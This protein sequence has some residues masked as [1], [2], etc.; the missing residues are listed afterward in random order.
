MKKH[1][2]LNDARLASWWFA[3]EDLDW[4]DRC[5]SRKWAARAKD[6]QTAGINTAVVFGF[7]FRWDFLP[8]LGRVFGAL[9]EVAEICHDHG[10]R[11]VEH[12]SATL[13]HRV[14]NDEDRW[15]IR[16]D[17][18]HHLP[19]YPD[20][21]D[22]SHYRGAPM[23]EWRQIS[24]RDG[25]PAF[26]NRYTS[27]CFCPNN[28]S[29]Q[30]AYLDLVARH[31]EALPLDAIMS[32]DLHYLPDAYSCGCEHC[33]ARFREEEGLELPPATDSSFWENYENPDFLKWIGARYRWNADHYRSLRESL[34]E[35]MPLWGCASNCVSAELA[36]IGFSPQ[37]WA[38]YCDAIFHEIYHVNQP[39]THDADIASDLAGFASLARHYDKPLLALFYAR[40]AADV[41]TWLETTA[42]HR[43]RPWLSK[44]PRTLGAPIEETLLQNGFP[45]D[46]EK[47]R[48]PEGD[49]HAIVFSESARDRLGPRA[50]EA[51]V[52]PFRRLFA[53]LSA[54]GKTV[55]VV[56]D[57]LWPEERP[58]QWKT[59]RAPGREFL[60]DTVEQR[61][62][63]FES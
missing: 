23:A 4:P 41:P 8:Y 47:A 20:T 34:P 28:P 17:N 24:A 15:E 13:V 33:R 42:F 43:A 39:G 16:N 19:F 38:P 56:F 7:H 53:E 14:R 6:F 55:H 37:H 31:I 60:S 49:L 30:Q 21:W 11:L 51:Y 22:Y 59:L 10:I 3:F 29:F 27:E 1:D 58:A 36:A 62:K 46:E 12:H 63:H 26:Y 32:D 48:R 45:F 44:Q 9:R 18:F 54:Q 2:W 57:S 35:T 50:R 52:E 5:L 40:K 25:K 61:L